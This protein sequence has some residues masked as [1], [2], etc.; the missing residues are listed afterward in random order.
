MLLGTDERDPALEPRFAGGLHR[1]QT[2]EGCSDH[3]EV[4][5]Q[6]AHLLLCRFNIY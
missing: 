1:T 5:L 2:R 6:L 3:G 4:L